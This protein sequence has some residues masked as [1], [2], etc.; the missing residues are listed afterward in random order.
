MG[1]LAVP[2][3]KQLGR[4]PMS[5][6]S[7]STLTH[8]IVYISF[9]LPPV[10]VRPELS[11]H[12]TIPALSLPLSSLCVTCPARYV[13]WYPRDLHKFHTLPLGHNHLNITTLASPFDIS[14]VPFASPFKTNVSQTIL[15]LCHGWLRQRVL[16]FFPSSLHG[17]ET[18]LISPHFLTD[19]SS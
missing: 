8:G 15:N 4:L 16:L 13:P 6:C 7:S 2:N 17:G 1:R 3:W 18:S 5:F 19:T 11:Q 14:T 12:S 10:S 9:I